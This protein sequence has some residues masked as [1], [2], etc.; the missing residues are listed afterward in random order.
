MKVRQWLPEWDGVHFDEEQFQRK[1]DDHFYLLSMPARDLRRLA[2]VHRRDVSKPRTGDTN[3]QRRH[4]VARSNEIARFVR[5]GY[6]LSTM[7]P[8]RRANAGRVS[9]RKPG[10]LPSSLIVNIM[11]AGDTRGELELRGPDAVTIRDADGDTAQAFYPKSWHTDGWRPE[12]AHPIEVIDGQHRLW[13]FDE[14]EELDFELPVVAFFNLD[15]SWQAYLF[16]SVNIKPKRINSSLAFDLYPLLRE[17]SWLTAGEGAAVYRETRAQELTEALW[18]APESP[19]YRRI[20]MLGDTG[21]RLQQPVTQAAFVRSLTSTFVR[22]WSTARTMVG[23]L[24][25]GLEVTG[26]DGAGLSWTRAQQAGFLVLLWRELELAIAASDADWAISLRENTDDLG[27]EVDV[28]PAFASPY[29]LLASD[30]GVRPILS[31]FNDLFY[32][33]HRDLGLRGYVDDEVEENLN[34]RAVSSW[35]E[36]WAK[37]SIAEFAGAACESLAT[38]DWRSSKAPSL[39]TEQR[40]WKLAF[41]GSGGYKEL[42]FQLLDHLIESSDD[43]VADAAE[44]VRQRTT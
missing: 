1:P 23:G 20:N 2:G 17:Q 13:A 40:R 10:W 30:Q 12:G 36:D 6:P 32:V 9:L 39:T 16:W 33:R 31:L 18:A 5:D 19:W 44:T 34:I 28:D 27:L 15:I 41:R 3:V 7:S 22:P 14:D 37:S 38:Y 4:D 24:F 43:Y 25:G 21:V 35:V 42:R 11:V 26:E 29:S 8:G